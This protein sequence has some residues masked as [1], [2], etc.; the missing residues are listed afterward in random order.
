METCEE[1]DL[2][3]LCSLTY[4]CNSLFSCDNIFLCC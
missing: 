2:Y 4:A 3:S 1:I